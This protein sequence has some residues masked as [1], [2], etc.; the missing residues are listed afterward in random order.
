MRPVSEASLILQFSLQLAH[1]T[2]STLLGWLM[3]QDWDAQYHDRVGA[4]ILICL[5]PSHRAIYC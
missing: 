2:K 1:I 4:V 3:R 5:Y